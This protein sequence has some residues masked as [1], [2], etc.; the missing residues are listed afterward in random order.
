MRTRRMVGVT[1]SQ[2]EDQLLAG[3]GERL[4]GED[5]AFKMGRVE[6]GNEIVLAAGALED[7]R[8]VRENRV[9]F[10]EFVGIAVV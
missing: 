3:G 4:D 2:G 1:V 6:P 9:A 10:Q 8:I 5:A 7:A